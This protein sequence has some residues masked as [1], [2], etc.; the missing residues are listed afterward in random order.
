MIYEFMVITGQE[1]ESIEQID[2]I[3]NSFNDILILW[4]EARN[5][6]GLFTVVLI[7]SKSKP[8]FGM[9]KFHSNYKY[10]IY[11]CLCMQ[12]TFQTEEVTARIETRKKSLNKKT[13][14]KSFHYRYKLLWTEKKQFAHIFLC[15]VPTHKFI[16]AS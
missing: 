13:I 1:K 10:I 11:Y 7:L 2:N 8:L 14:L 6:A 9:L 3:L 16:V 15:D 5:G 4:M 12:V